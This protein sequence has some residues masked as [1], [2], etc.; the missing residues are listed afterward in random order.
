MPNPFGHVAIVG[1][2]GPSLHG[3]GFNGPRSMH[4]HVP[5]PSGAIQH[6]AGAMQH[7]A[8]ALQHFAVALPWDPHNL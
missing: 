5:V 3:H 2:V 8:G 7:L 1:R 4:D 6:F